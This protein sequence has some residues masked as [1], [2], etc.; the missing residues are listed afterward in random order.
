MNNKKLQQQQQQ[1][2]GPVG[3]VQKFSVSKKSCA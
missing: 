1:H 2:N 3:Y